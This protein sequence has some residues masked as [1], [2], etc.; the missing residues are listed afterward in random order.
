M[1]LRHSRAGNTTVT[2][3]VA[4]VLLV[5]GAFFYFRLNSKL[6][7]VEAAGLELTAWIGAVDGPDHNATGGLTTYLI[8]LKTVLNTHL[9][10]KAFPAGPAHSGAPHNHADPPPPP[11]W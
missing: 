4:V 3:I 6:N 11:P 7:R 10:Q 5:V 2:I 9:G 8:N 1:R